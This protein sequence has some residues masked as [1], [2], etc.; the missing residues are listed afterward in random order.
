MNEKVRRKINDDFVLVS[1]YVDDKELLDT[2]IY[3]AVQNKKI[4]SVGGIWADFQI[5]NFKQNSQPL[6]VLLTPDQ[7]VLTAPR[8]YNAD[9][10]AYDSFLQCGLNAF[11]EMNP[12]VLGSAK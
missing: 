8:S 9:A 2:I 12:A 3:S 4:R 11:K 1:L 7:Q 6:Y 10:E 5:T